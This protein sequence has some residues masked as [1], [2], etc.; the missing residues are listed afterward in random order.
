MALFDTSLL[1]SFVTVAQVSSFTRAAELLHSTQSTVSAHIRRLEQ[2]A[3]CA[4]FSRSTRSVALTSQGQTFL[5]FAETILRL[6]REAEARLRGRRYEGR[7]RLGVSEDFAA[8][9]L[10]RILRGFRAS[11]PAGSLGIEIGIGATLFHMLEEQRL[12]VVVGGR[13]RPEEAGITLWTEPLVW[14]FARE[15][16]PPQPLP[17]ALFPE[18][19]PYRQAALLALAGARTKWDIVCTSSSLAGVRAAA[20]SGIAVTPLPQS[21]IGTELR[22]LGPEDELPLLGSVEY[23]VRIRD[24]AQ[25]EPV[26]TLVDIVRSSLAQA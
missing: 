9:W 2:Q 20:V 7:L 1:R 4:L 19:C 15:G 11:Y 8:T 22:V 3:G 17:V 5:G 26:R 10:P 12:D 23:L 6:N 13:C 24:G 16:R 14:A 21:L 18:P 25:P